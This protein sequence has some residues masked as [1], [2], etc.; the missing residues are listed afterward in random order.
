MVP[1]PGFLCNAVA[2]EYTELA[3]APPLA[4]ALTLSRCSDK[5]KACCAGDWL[6]AD[7]A[8]LSLGELL[9]EPLP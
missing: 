8:P 3:R 5:D 7:C 4:P 1:A 6:V 2:L 9:S